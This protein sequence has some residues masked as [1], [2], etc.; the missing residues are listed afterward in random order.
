VVEEYDIEVLIKSSKHEN[1]F[2]HIYV[3]R[4]TKVHNFQ[5]L[6]WEVSYGY[7]S[8]PKKYFSNFAFSLTKKIDRTRVA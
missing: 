7:K 1:F 5:K 3:C 2:S 8:A 6:R 4:D